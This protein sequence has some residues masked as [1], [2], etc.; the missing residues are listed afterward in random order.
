MRPLNFDYM[1]PDYNAVFQM[2]ADAL[3]FIRNNP[4][5]LPGI[6][7]YYKEHI[8]QFIMDWGVTVDPKNVERGLP[9]LIPFILFPK[10]EDWIN[11][12]IWCWHNQKPMMTL[13]T[14]QMGFSW[15][16]MAVGCSLSIFNEGMAIGVGSRKEIYVDSVGDPKS[17]FHKGRTFMAN[18]PVEFRAGW[19]AGKHAPHM[20]L[21]FP[22][23]GA[24]IT[25]EAGDNIG[26]GN[27][28]S[29]YLVDESAFLE[30]PHLVE[31]SL[32][33]TTN[34]RID[35]STPNGYGN[36]FADKC[37]G[38]KIKL[39][40]FH[41]QDD[42]RKDIAW[43]NR[44]CEELDPVTVAQEI[45]CDFAASVE[46]VLIPVSW[47]K[48]SVDAHLRL[49][50]PPSGMKSGGLDVADEGKDMNAF[51]GRHGIVLEYVD[52]W[53]GKGSDIFRTAFKA[54]D[55]C[56]AMGYELFKYD[57]DGLGAGV[58]GDAR[59]IA[60][61]R[62]DNGQRPIEAEA[63][64]GSEAVFNP[65]GEDVKGRK[66]KDYFRDRKAQAWWALR[67]RFEKTYGW[68]VEGRVCDP[69]DIISISSAIKHHSKLVG[70][71][72]QPTYVTNDIG[73]IVVNKAPDNTKSPNLA[74]AVMIAFSVTARK[75][76]TI[77]QY[78]VAAI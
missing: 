27:T 14:R 12:V 66:N 34:C 22:E 42:P 74:D 9:S 15:L 10:Q 3:T 1:N 56:D 77:S 43:Y 73:K 39:F 21:I 64:R 61:R 7:A 65:E 30:R 72:S 5:E 60:Q 49:Q 38:G 20:R 18:L 76:I 63:F 57:S 8:P 41:W 55:I 25:G 45:D 35:I 48:A 26:R 51:C 70:E 31:A 52:E 37:N 4:G 54:H 59:I 68:V 28:T 6:K 40:T 67:R 78:A 16:A 71:L 33:Q 50:I 62:T 47:I 69:D 44:Q 17:L 53:S 32:S 75:P 46:G 2:R 19:E 11:D 23:T 29:I 36:P 24:T 58:R 13:K